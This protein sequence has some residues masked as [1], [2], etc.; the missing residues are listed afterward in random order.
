MRDIGTLANIAIQ[1]VS[2]LT[3]GGDMGLKPDRNGKCLCIFHRDRN[4]SLKL[5][6]GNRGYYCFVCGAHGDVVDLTAAITGT[7]KTDALRL[8]NDRYALCLPIDGRD[9]GG[10]RRAKEIAEKRAKDALYVQTRTETLT[11]AVEA[12]YEVWL[13]W[14]SCS[15]STR[16]VGHSDAITSAY[17]FCKWH[18]EIAW[19]DYQHAQDTLYAWRLEQQA[20]KD[21]R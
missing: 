7:R 13:D 1:S 17:A 20:R 6:P 14:K 19:E 9:D 4:P 10:L 16:P 5:Y 15:E 3:V 18:E 8:L 2:A 21:G 11:K 12:A